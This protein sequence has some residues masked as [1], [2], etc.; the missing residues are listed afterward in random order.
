MIVLRSDS[1]ETHVRRHATWG[2]YAQDNFISNEAFLPLIKAGLFEYA[3]DLLT[4]GWEVVFVTERGFEFFLTGKT[5]MPADYTPGFSSTIEEYRRIAP[6]T[7]RLSEQ[8][9]VAGLA[10]DLWD[11]EPE[12]A[13]R[14]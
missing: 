6:H 14:L 2:M 10:Y 7:H 3:D 5:T 9:E 1:G 11:P 8:V 4:D 12:S 13:P